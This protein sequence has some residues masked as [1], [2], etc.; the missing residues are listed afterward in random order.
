[1]SFSVSAFI[2]KPKSQ[3]AEVG[4]T[5]VFEAQTEKEDVKVRWQRDTKDITGSDKYTISAEGN[6][7]SL[8]ISNVTPEDSTGYAVISGGS[9]VKFELKINETEGGSEGFWYLC[10]LLYPDHTSDLFAPLCH[11]L[12]VTLDNHTAPL[13]HPY[14]QPLCVIPLN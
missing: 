8:T 14:S 5:V 6:K 10:S 2:K 9:K 11:F 4:A 13:S 3:T 1:M 12:F 7:H